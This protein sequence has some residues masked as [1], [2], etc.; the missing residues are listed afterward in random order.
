MNFLQIL[1]AETRYYKNDIND[2]QKRMEMLKESPMV[3]QMLD[4]SYSQIGISSA[5]TID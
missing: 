2:P 3:W 5:Y 1:I 4:D